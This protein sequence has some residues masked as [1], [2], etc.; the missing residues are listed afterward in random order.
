MILAKIILIPKL[1]SIFAVDWESCDE[2]EAE[3]D[4]ADKAKARR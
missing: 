4:D 1:L 3:L 2:E